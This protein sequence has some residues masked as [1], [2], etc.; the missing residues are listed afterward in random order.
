MSYTVQLAAIRT[1]TA[2][3]QIKRRV[4]DRKTRA[5]RGYRVRYTV[6][7]YYQDKILK[8]DLAAVGMSPSSEHH[9][10]QCMHEPRCKAHLYTH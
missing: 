4:K 9:K 6:S 3:G 2:I 10:C 1:C 8:Q 5:S 7:H